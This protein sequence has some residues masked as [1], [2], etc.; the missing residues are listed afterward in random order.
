MGGK[1]V[2]PTYEQVCSGRSG[3][4]ETLQ[5][6]YDPAQVSY[7]EFLALFWQW[8][9]PTSLN[10]QGPDVGEQYRS[11]IFTYDSEQAQKA[12]R[13]KEIL[14][15]AKVFPGSIVTEIV[16]A[17]TFW[18][19]EEY[20]QDYLAKNPGGYCSHHVGSPKIRQVLSEAGLSLKR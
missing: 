15:K 14:E 18:P 6:E 16:P 5:M 12:L 9:D 13:S 20:H 3:H 1:T 19:A 10:R 8:H 4:A 17:G 11:V 2:D 7:E